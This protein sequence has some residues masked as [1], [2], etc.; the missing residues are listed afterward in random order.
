[1]DIQSHVHFH[2][3]GPVP[4]LSTL[5]GEVAPRAEVGRTAAPTPVVASSQFINVYPSSKQSFALGSRLHDTADSAASKASPGAQQVEVKFDGNER[6]IASGSGNGDRRFWAVLDET[7][8]GKNS[9]AEL[10]KVQE[11]YP[12]AE[13]YLQVSR[14]SSGNVSVAGV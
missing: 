12:D 11:R 9:F 7:H 4:N 2:F 3:N 14:D 13:Q 6:V 1:M 10:A 5:L 8:L